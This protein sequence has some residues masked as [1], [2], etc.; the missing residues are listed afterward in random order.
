MTKVILQAAIILLIVIIVA[1]FVINSGGSSDDAPGKLNE[2]LAT[3]AD[4][5]NPNTLEKDFI[6]PAPPP[7]EYDERALI[8]ISMDKPFYKPNE[9]VFIEA[10]MIDSLTKKPLHSQDYGKFKSLNLYCDA[11]ILDSFG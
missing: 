9:I 7:P 3:A 5:F 10:F 11:V 2:A 1:V 4:E 8:H 6:K